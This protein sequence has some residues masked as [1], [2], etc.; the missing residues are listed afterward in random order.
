MFYKLRIRFSKNL[1]IMH[2]KSIDFIDKDQEEWMRVISGN[3]F[4]IS[5]AADLLKH[6]AAKCKYTAV[7]AMFARIAEAYD[8][9]PKY[10]LTALEWKEAS[11]EAL[12]RSGCTFHETDKLYNQ[13]FKMNRDI[14]DKYAKDPF[15]GMR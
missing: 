15:Q 6:K 8:R 11:K 10:G 7:A 1:I 13:L 3:N 5:Y 9:K 2:L 14:H 4:N 12:T